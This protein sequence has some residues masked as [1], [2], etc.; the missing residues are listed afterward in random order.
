MAITDSAFDPEALQ[1]A[2]KLLAP[3]PFR[4]RAWPVL[5]AAAF[6]AVS[7]LTLAGTMILTPPASEHMVRDSN[8]I[9]V[10]PR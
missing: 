5:L 3:R 6:A 10:Q 1:R 7:A 4:E 2:R 9:L 8:G